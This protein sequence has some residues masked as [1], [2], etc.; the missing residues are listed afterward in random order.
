[1]LPWQWKNAHKKLIIWGHL[2]GAVL[3]LHLL[4]GCIFFLWLHHG[5]QHIAL[6]MQR[7]V[8]AIPVVF[9]RTLS[10]SQT[11]VRTIQSSAASKN[12]VPK[13]NNSS[14]HK[15]T[16][17]KP[18]PIKKK[19]TKPITPKKAA[20]KKEIKKKIAPKKEVVQKKIEPPKKELPKKA[21]EKVV[22]EPVIQAPP[23][24]Q[25][26]P[27]NALEEQPMAVGTVSSVNQ[28]EAELY[29]LVAQ[30]W[31]PPVGIAVAHECEVSAEIGWQQEIK[32]VWISKKSGILMYDL[33][34]R[35]AVMQTTF[36][37]WTRGKTVTIRFVQ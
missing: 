28:E 15:T 9:S 24:A 30:H 21:E 3:M 7:N 25:P 29:A 6:T 5:A 27:A 2:V 22:Q 26:L 35:K 34:A 17:V 23:L 31:M 14:V 1:M 18:A 33:A 37:L 12:Q 11:A 8:A 4:F 13:K 36:P 10:K 32:K 20:P 19:H 16:I